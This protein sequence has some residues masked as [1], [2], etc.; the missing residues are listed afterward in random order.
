MPARNRLKSREWEAARAPALAASDICVWCGHPGARD[1]GHI[2]PASRFPAMAYDP[3][4]IVPM[5]GSKA[6]CPQCPLRRAAKGR[7]MIRRNCNAEV[8]ARI[9]WV[10]A[11]PE[12]TGSRDW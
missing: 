10:E 5:H 9:M 6:S 4:N 7:R 2:Y 1:G 12:G 8:G 11:I 3:T